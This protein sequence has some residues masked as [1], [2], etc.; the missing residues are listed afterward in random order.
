ME[1]W[2]CGYDVGAVLR[3]RGPDAG[4]V[5]RLQKVRNRQLGEVVR[6]SIAPPDKPPIHSKRNN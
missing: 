3:S 5:R 4:G 2:V 1:T 6:T